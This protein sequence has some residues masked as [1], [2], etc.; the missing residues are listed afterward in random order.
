MKTI[1]LEFYFTDEGIEFNGLEQDLTQLESL[2]LIRSL[3]IITT[4]LSEKLLIN[5]YE[6]IL[7]KI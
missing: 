7:N 3:S 1:N 4:D 6:S 5:E 2:A